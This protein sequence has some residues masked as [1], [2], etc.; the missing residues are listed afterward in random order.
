MKRFFLENNSRYA[1]RLQLH[2]ATCTESEL[3]ARERFKSF[4]LLMLAQ[5]RKYQSK[6]FFLLEICPIYFEIQFYHFV[7]KGSSKILNNIIAIAHPRYVLNIICTFIHV[8]ALF[9]IKSLCAYTDDDSNQIGV[10]VYD[11]VIL[12]D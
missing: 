3:R 5:K 8:F 2:N 9:A 10:D 4:S 11:P 6:T 7:A 12:I 1:I